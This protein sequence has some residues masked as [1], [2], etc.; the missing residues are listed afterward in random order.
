STKTSSSCSARSPRYS[1]MLLARPEARPC[2]EAPR[3]GGVGHPLPAVE[4]D[5][6]GMLTDVGR[7]P[8]P[9]PPAREEPL[10]VDSPVVLEVADRHHDPPVVDLMLG[11]AVRRACGGAGSQHLDAMAGDLMHR[12]PK[13]P[14]NGIDPAA[15]RLSSDLPVPDSNVRNEQ[16]HP[17]V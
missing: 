10:A 15:Q 4:S 13:P 3:E 1:E 14:K 12:S 2:G 9:F 7:V 6:L 8:M 16:L 11:S 17:R 5:R